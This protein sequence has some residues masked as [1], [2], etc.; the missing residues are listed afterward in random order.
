MEIDNK[1][2][3]RLEEWQQR[4][5]SLPAFAEFYNNLLHI[6]TDVQANIFTPQH[7][8]SQAE[9]NDRLRQGIPLLEGGA[10]SIDWPALQNLVKTI[11]RAASEY[12][13]AASGDRETLEEI[14]SNLLLLKELTRAWYDGLPLLP[15]ISGCSVSVSEEVLAAV[16]HAAVKPFI[17]IHSEILIKLVDQEL[18][19]RGYCPICGGMPDFAFLDRERGARWLLCCR[20]DAQWLF[21]RLQCPYCGTQAQ[22][23]LAYLTDDSGL[24]RLYICEQCRCYLKAIDLRQTQAEILLPL[25]RL[26]TL[27]MDRQG[28]EMGYKGGWASA[29]KA[30]Q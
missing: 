3:K 16:I 1:I 4:E 12:L 18:W 23:D 5:G 21:Q 13:K 10:L 29:A 7:I 30:I 11:A 24:Y 22:D 8:P 20:C 19:R 17:S 15:I 6:Q 9:V 27:D 28:Q 2:L 25:E 26:L 14:A